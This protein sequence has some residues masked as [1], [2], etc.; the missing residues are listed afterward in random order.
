MLD[1]SQEQVLAL[2]FKVF[3]ISIRG[4][5]V[6]KKNTLYHNFLT[7]VKSDIWNIESLYKPSSVSAYCCF[8]KNS[9]Q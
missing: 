4:Y 9:K 6:T 5:V 1:V 3:T 2:L 8:L 7:V